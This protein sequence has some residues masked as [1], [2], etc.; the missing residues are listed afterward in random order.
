MSSGGA[1]R[2]SW[3]LAQ[4][5]ATALERPG[6]KRSRARDVVG[7]TFGADMQKEYLIEL[8]YAVVAVK[9]SNGRVKLNQL[10]HPTASGAVSG[11]FW[12]R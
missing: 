2:V 5:R 12:A 4:V 10:F 1:G 9:Q 7:C 6:A 3:A 11:T 8:G